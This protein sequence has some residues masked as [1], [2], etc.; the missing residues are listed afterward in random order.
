MPISLTG[1]NYTENFDSLVNSGTTDS[2]LPSGWEFLESGSNADTTYGINN[3]NSNTGNTYSYGATDDTD[4]AFGGLQSGSLTPTIGVSFTNNTGTTITSLNISYRGEQ[5]RL[6][7]T[8]RQDR[9]DFQYSLDATSL[10][11]GSWIDVDSLDFSSPNTSTTGSLDGN[12]AGNNTTVTGTISGLNI[13][14]GATFYLRWQ[15]LNASGADDGLA[16]DDFSLSIPSST[17]TVNLSV[18]SNTGTET[19]TTIIT[20]TATASSAVTGEQTVNLAVSG[21]DITASDYYLSNTTITIADGQT[22]GSV[23]FIVADDAIPEG[24][25][26]ATLTISSPSAGISLGATTSQNITITNN[27]GSFLT[28][29]GGI[30]SANGAEIP[31][32]D[33]GSD[34]LFVVAGTTVEIY[35]VSNTGSLTAVGSLT[36]GITPAVDTALIPNSVAVKN[37]VVAV[38]YAVRTTNNA[39]LTGK[40]AFFNAADGNYISAV[41]V[42]ALPD[43]LTF[44]PDGTKIL[45]ANEGE[46]NSYGQADSVDPEGSVS[47]IDIANGVA[48]ATVQTATFTS[49]NS[50][51]PTLRASGVRI[52]G[53]NATVA[54]DLEPEYITVSGDG[55]TAWITLQ[56]NNAIAIL[57]IANATITQILPLGVKNH[58][59]PGNGIDASDR[60]SGI[61]IANWPVFGLYQPDAIASFVVNSQTYY[62]TANEGDARDYTGFAE[63]IRV[64][65]AGYVLD[66]TV[67]PNAA[68]LKQNANLGRLT[69]TNATGDIDGD[70]DYDRIEVFGARSFSI[71]D[72]NGNQVFDSGYQLEQITLTKVPTL[73][74]SNGAGDSFDSR[75]DNKGPEPEGVVIGVIDNRTYA[76]IGLE[77]TGD[78]IVYDV[79]N[80]NQPQFVQYINTPADVSPEGLTFISAADSP[81]GKPLLVTANE[82]SQTVAVF[83]ITPPIRIRDI[84]GTSHT[85]PLDGQTVNNVAGIVTAIR[86]NGFYFQDSNPDNDDSTSEAIFVFTSSVPTV[87]VGDSV[88]VSGTVT[89]FLPGGSSGTNNLTLTQIISPAITVL[90]SGNE[91]PAATI[92]GDGGRTIPTTVISDGQISGTFDPVQEGI[93]FYESLE[94]MRVQIN[95]PVAVSPTN[96]FGEIWVLADNGANATGRTARGG[97]GISAN[98]FN[99]ERIQIDDTLLNPLSGSYLTPNV[100]VGAQLDTI[101]GVVDYSFGNYEVLPNTL[102]T[103]DTPS[104]LTRE[105]TNLAPGDNQ[106]T[107]ATFNVENLDPND[108]ATKF[109]N[110]AARIVNNLRSPDIIS[111][112]EIQD[113]NGAINDSVVDASVTYQALIDAIVAAGGPT[114]QYRQ[115]D[116]VDDTNGGE[117]GGNIRVGFLFNPGRVSFVDIPGGTST[118]STSVTN[119]NG[120]PTLSASPGLIDPTNT[121]FDSS[122]KPLVGQFTFNGQTV[123]IV[124]NHFNSKGGDQPLFG[125]NQPPTLTSETQRNQQAEIVKNFVQSILAINPNANVIV[126]GDLNDFEFS[127]PLTTLK[128]AGLNTLI[129]TLPEN[130]RYTYNFQGNAQT[131]DHILVSNNLLSNLDGFDVVHINSEFYDQD[132]DHDPTVARFNI[133]SN[134]PPTV[135]IPIADQ[136]APTGKT[137]NFQFAPNAFTDVEDGTNLTYTAT[138]ADGNELPNWLTFN[139]DTRTFSGEYSTPETLTIQVTAKDSQDA[140]V[141]DEFVLTLKQ[142]I[143][144]ELG[145]NIIRGT[146]EGDVIEG[147][148][149]RQYLI[150]RGGNDNL[151]GGADNDY[152]FGGAGDD[153]IKGGDDAGFDLLYGNEGNDTLDGGDGNDNL[154]G[155]TGNDLLI[156]G[157]GNDIYTVDSFGDTVVEN[158]GEGTDK[159]NSFIDYTLGDYLENLTL[160]GNAAINGTGNSLNNHIIGNNRDNTLYGLD[161]DDWLMGKGGNDTL[162]GGIG[163]DRLDGG[164]GDDSLVGGAG[165]D[166][167]EIDSFGDEIIEAEDGGIDTVISVVD[168][169][170]GDNIE[171]LTLVRNATDGG[172]NELNNR[173]IGNNAS[174]T[175]VGLD[176]DDYLAGGTG[177]DTLI[178]GDGNDTLVGGRDADRFDLTGVLLGGFDTI[179]D[180]RTSEDIVQLSANELQLTAGSLDS[181]LFVLGTSATTETHRLIY[182][183][184]TGELFFDTDGSGSTE[185][186]KIALFSNRAALTAASFDVV[187][188]F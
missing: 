19:G 137:F 4:R 80:P 30:T 145:N 175:L 72:A 44:T 180:F 188:E 128:S 61:N 183:R 91:L 176:G 45:V 90:S 105:V 41:D 118:S 79:S 162:Y 85:S 21:T 109:N 64:G 46:P 67:F 107:V 81:T 93:D 126:A 66:P 68:T 142:P 144:G 22:V 167:Y 110:I 120:T 65:N 89:E 186:V 37:G 47:I 82:V 76:F 49:F 161:G 70:G 103:V 157:T 40:V 88:T 177:N 115:I 96:Q 116:P 23:S 147:L 55:Q 50:Q 150:G 132:S 57:D 31:A 59:L 14:N 63:E 60:D 119:T 168:W 25:E 100:S 7:T 158:D 122:R 148:D 53:P 2:V 127:H 179:V 86:N 18:N 154:D 78:V 39:Q 94:G 52:F 153:N 98:D 28:K 140:T 169:V 129:E 108:G 71:W 5:W 135:A 133:S 143:Q 97:I 165:N 113:N 101:V 149:G 92:L 185:S 131:L 15:D 43:M 83:E 170:L 12:A 156:G 75:S 20:V 111:V 48:N 42:G 146:N 106:L 160:L 8:G 136:T 141:S 164:K 174:N 34:R 87:Q 99:P 36:P 69:V 32:F 125:V 117:P 6:G 10:S 138:L 3:G 171:N 182:N 104:T 121:A 62:I 56:E 38:A 184:T 33:P 173:I 178:G 77:R 9:L 27:D 74:N 114:Y 1:T 159:V 84:Q 123:Y 26:T 134:T 152:V 16:I 11:T 124:A 151:D 17:P 58:S 102:P 112:E 181:S 187:P 139:P 155:G 13:A 51:I 95:N 172:G 166:I 130:E 73:F 24:T 163:N 29:V 35:T 54:Q